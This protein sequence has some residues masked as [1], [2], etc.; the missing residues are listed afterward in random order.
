MNTKSTVLA[1]AM[2]AIPLSAFAAS[3]PPMVPMHPRLT[4]TQRKE[5]HTA[6][7]TFRRKSAA[8]RAQTRAQILAGISPTSR[9]ALASVVSQLAITPKPNLWAAAKRLDATLSPTD[10]HSILAAKKNLRTQEVELRKAMHAQLVAELPAMPTPPMHAPAKRKWAMHRHAPNA[11]M[12]L[13]RTSL[14]PLLGMHWMG[15]R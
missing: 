3:A 13:L 1:L 8:L 7:R 15:R 5:L 2:A 6:L 9:N 4:Q 14:A 11:G 12:I 10:V